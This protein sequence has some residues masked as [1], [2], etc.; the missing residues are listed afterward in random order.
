MGKEKVS[1]KNNEKSCSFLLVIGTGV[2]HICFPIMLMIIFEKLNSI[3]RKLKDGLI[4]A[5]S[6]P[7]T[8]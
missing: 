4:K 8:F 5:K 2:Y 7:I 1:W 3:H 6:R